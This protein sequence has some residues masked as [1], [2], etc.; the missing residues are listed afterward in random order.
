MLMLELTTAVLAGGGGGGHCHLAFLSRSLL[1]DIV[2][3]I[4]ILSTDRFAIGDIIML[5]PLV[6]FV[7]I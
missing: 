5:T 1:E 4:M 7:E 2:N 6:G 3:G